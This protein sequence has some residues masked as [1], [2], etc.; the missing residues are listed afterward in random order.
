MALEMRHATLDD[1]PRIQEIIREIFD[2]QYKNKPDGLCGNDDCGQMSA[3]YVFSALGFY[4]VCR[5]DYKLYACRS[6]R[7]FCFA[8]C[9]VGEFVE[10]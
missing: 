10:P 1:M 9:A 3:W 4:P 5:H 8:F 6:M 7:M 2:T